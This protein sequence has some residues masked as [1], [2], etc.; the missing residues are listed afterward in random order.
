MPTDWTKPFPKDAIVITR[1]D[2]DE[3]MFGRP[4]YAR[5]TPINRAIYQQLEAERLEW[6]EDRN[7][8][9]Q[10]SWELQE[11]EKQIMRD[12]R[13]VKE[14]REFRAEEVIAKLG[15]WKKY[16]DLKRW[17]ELDEW[18]TNHPQRLDETDYL[19]GLLDTP[20]WSD[21]LALEPKPKPVE[22]RGRPKG[23]VTSP[24]TKA[25]LGAASRAAWE[26][27]RAR[28]WVDPRTKERQ[29]LEERKAKE[30]Y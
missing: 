25:K 15:K 16:A 20:R 26:R 23:S 30:P 6:L 18:L 19:F 2:S 8:Q 22:R 24:E 14:L 7:M 28:G 1:P 4:A 29:E 3:V 13:A 21:P 27:R 10:K 5:G 9:A 11:R 17:D 12:R